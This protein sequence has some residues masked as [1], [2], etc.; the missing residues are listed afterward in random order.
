MAQRLKRL[1][2]M[3]ETWV[4][5]L[6]GKI[7][8]RRKWQPTPAFWPGESHGQRSLVVCICPWG[9][10]ELDRLNAFPYCDLV[11]LS[12][13]LGYHTCLARY[14]VNTLLFIQVLESDVQFLTPDI[15]YSFLFIYKSQMICHFLLEM[16]PNA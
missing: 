3:W 13:I 7:P 16:L 4:R 10:R 6:V 12:L 2:G 8:W 1:P 14:T 15:P 9:R 11:S 5:S